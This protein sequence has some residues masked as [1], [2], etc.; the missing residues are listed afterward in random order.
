MTEI[1]FDK[2]AD[3]HLFYCNKF[4][5]V[6]HDSI[7]QDKESIHRYRNGPDLRVM[8]LEYQ[9]D[10]DVLEIN[11]CHYSARKKD[12]DNPWNKHTFLITSKKEIYYYDDK[13]KQLVLFG[14]RTSIADDVPDIFYPNSYNNAV[15][16]LRLIM[17]W[18]TMEYKSNIPEIAAFLKD[19]NVLNNGAILNPES[20][21]SLE[22]WFSSA[23]LKKSKA[24]DKMSEITSIELPSVDTKSIP[25]RKFEDFGELGNFCFYQKV[26]SDLGVLRFFVRNVKHISHG[27]HFCENTEAEESF[28]CYF[29]YKKKMLK[30]CVFYSKENRWI[31]KSLSTIDTWG[32]SSCCFV[33]NPDE[34]AEM[35]KIGY[36]SKILSA[37]KIYSPLA[38]INLLRYPE[39]EQLWKMGYSDCAFIIAKEKKCQSNLKTRLF[40]YTYNGKGK[41]LL[42]K[43]GIPK[44]YFNA[45]IKCYATYTKDYG[46][47]YHPL[48]DYSLISYVSLY[49]IFEDT[50]PVEDFED[51]LYVIS[52]FVHRVGARLSDCLDYIVNGNY[53]DR[54]PYWRWGGYDFSIDVLS[55]E[56]QA[57]LKKFLKICLKYFRK[58]PDSLDQ[59]ADALSMYM[60]NVAYTDTFEADWMFTSLSDITRLHDNLVDFTAHKK[61]CARENE[62]KVRR[63]IDKKRAYLNYE[64]EQYVIRLPKDSAEIYKEGTVQHICI[65]SMAN[66]HANGYTT[67][68]FIRKKSDPEKPFY[69]LEVSRNY[70]C[71]IHGFGNCWLGNNPE[72][73]PSVLKFAEQNHLTVD[74]KILTSTSKSFVDNG[75]YIDMPAVS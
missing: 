58:E 20:T 26:N 70:I 48:N 59:I 37:P 34:M 29:A 57:P 69:A 1:N 50:L 13:E 16:L 24:A 36:I 25:P 23:S 22:K 74:N 68:M 2:I 63:A 56:C 32:S 10:R 41:N 3:W 4:I 30:C 61:M 64:D 62:E 44:K 47:Y 51:M 46:D 73:I 5:D 75:V 9:S 71:Q 66:S 39:L 12:N 55:P 72:V 15:G 38:I 8:Y 54:R 40:P 42:E 11:L 27:C 14:T 53:H 65:G 7:A 28:R 33:A 67:L 43:S 19:K 52:K 35:P 31:I 45:Y 21:W 49:N 17:N 6:K 18:G 60:E